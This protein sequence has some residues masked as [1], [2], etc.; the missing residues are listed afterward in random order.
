MQQQPSPSPWEQL[1]AELIAEI[2]SYLSPVQL[3]RV[4][5]TCRRWNHVVCG[6][7]ALMAQFELRF[8]SQSAPFSDDHHEQ[9]K[10]AANVTGR[11][12]VAH[13]QLGLGGP[14]W[15]KIGETIQRLT[16]V[17]NNKVN[18]L[19]ELLRMTPNLKSLSLD[20]CKLDLS[21]DYDSASSVDF[22]LEHLSELNFHGEFVD[23]FCQICPNLEALNYQYASSQPPETDIMP[24]IRTTQATLQ[25]LTL[26]DDYMSSDEVW[27]I[28]PLDRL[29]LKELSLAFDWEDPW[30]EMERFVALISK[31][32]ALELLRLEPVVTDD[33]DIKRDFDLQIWSEIKA[34]LPKLK[35]LYLTIDVSNRAKLPTFLSDMQQLECLGIE[36]NQSFK[37]DLHLGAISNT[38]L[39]S[40]YLKTVK[41]NP[42]DLS[43][44][45][46]ETPN[47]RHLGIDLV[48]NDILRSISCL[49]Q[50]ERLEIGS[51]KVSQPDYMMSSVKTLSC[52]PS[53][54]TSLKTVVTV[55]PNTQHLTVT[56]HLTD[57]DV[58]ILV[59]ELKQLKTLNLPKRSAMTAVVFDHIIEHGHS[60]ERL[61]IQLDRSDIL[62]EQLAQLSRT[63]RV[64][65]ACEDCFVRAVKNA[66][67]WFGVHYGF[68][69]WAP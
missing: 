69:T 61:Q 10:M 1:P 39:T 33:T 43:V 36:M 63:I 51:C 44:F 66:C 52:S 19:I 42:D 65:P 18:P 47:I 4:R 8:D 56:G 9:S 16:V 27:N 59:R 58:L 5:L 13:V 7:P 60:L 11:Y 30:T 37:N 22:K 64:R 23:L 28:C 54:T 46:A 26:D 24:L 17:I 57:D 40:L 14:L 15:G 35:S 49:K 45:F 53:S 68:H 38:N 25:K 41:L 29:H 6:T 34:K 67:E 48:S 31:Q 3:E 55:F 2:F 62:P 12:S 32:P 21:K 20:N 50:L